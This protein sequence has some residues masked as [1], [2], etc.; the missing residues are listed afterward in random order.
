MKTLPCVGCGWCC[1]DTQCGVSHRLHGYQ[2]RCP[3][4]AWDALDG[5]YRCRLILDPR[6]GLDLAELRAGRGCCAPLNPWRA[7]VI[8]RD[9][10]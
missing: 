1:L 5:R 7:H 10:A 4:L 9:T 2:P 8:R 6:P 3:E